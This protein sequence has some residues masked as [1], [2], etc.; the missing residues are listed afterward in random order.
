M[1]SSKEVSQ[2]DIWWVNFD[3]TIGQ[4]IQKIRPAIV[5]D[6]EGFGYDDMRIVIPF[7]SVKEHKRE[8]IA[9]ALWLIEIDDYKSLGLKEKSFLNVHQI[10]SCSLKRFDNKMGEADDA[11]LFTIHNALVG[12][13]NP[14]YLLKN[15]K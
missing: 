5:I 9:K 6:S 1:T 3:P 2:G 14:R 13:L 15:P 11:L 4:E 10:K 12:I 8:L 7:S